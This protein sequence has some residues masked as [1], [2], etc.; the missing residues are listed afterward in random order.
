MFGLFPKNDDDQTLRM[1]RFLIAFGAPPSNLCCENDGSGSFYF[2]T[3]LWC[4]IVK[5]FRKADYAGVQGDSTHLSPHRKEIV[6]L[7]SSS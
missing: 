6:R 7:T 4:F 2:F 3:F 1:K 5:N